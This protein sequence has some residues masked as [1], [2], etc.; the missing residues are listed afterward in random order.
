MHFWYVGTLV[1][2]TALAH[3]SKDWSQK[4][5]PLA[6]CLCCLYNYCINCRLEKKASIED[7]YLEERPLAIDTLNIS[8]V[9]SIPIDDGG[10]SQVD[11]Q[12]DIGELLDG[13]NHF[14]DVD[15]NNIQ[16]LI[17]HHVRLGN[18]P[19]DAMLQRVKDT[20]LKH[21]VPQRWLKKK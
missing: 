18:H 9:G 5:V 6:I 11:N 2:D 3:A 16:K 14:D 1:G 7:A 4:T 20:G 10:I 12:G 8:C 21:L 15:M 13:S 19:R 17:Q